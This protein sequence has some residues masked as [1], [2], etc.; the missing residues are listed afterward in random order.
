M[1]NK[2]SS[3]NSAAAFSKPRLCHAPEVVG[4]GEQNATK[5]SNVLVWL[6]VCLVICLAVVVLWLLPELLW[7]ALASSSS[8]PPL[9]LP[10][11]PPAPSASSSSSNISKGEQHL[12]CPAH[13]FADVTLQINFSGFGKNLLLILS[14]AYGAYNHLN[15]TSFAT[16]DLSR[17]HWL[18]V[19]VTFV[20]SHYLTFSVQKWVSFYL[21]YT[22]LLDITSKMKSQKII[23]L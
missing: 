9:P 6:F 21:K 20:K 10:P 11:L 3:G 7:V 8:P 16:D 12:G 17:N 22:V 4:Q 15:P 18:Q 13:H 14:L 19:W 23:F 5:F 2:I 1:K